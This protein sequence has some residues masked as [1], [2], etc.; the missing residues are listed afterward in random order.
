MER[1]RDE[2]ERGGPEKKIANERDEKKRENRGR[3]TK[4][5]GW[6][7]FL[8]LLLFPQKIALESGLG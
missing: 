7:V 1:D 4:E 5:R 8:L 6:W 3:K 2:G